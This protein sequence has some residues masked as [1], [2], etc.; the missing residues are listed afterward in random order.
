MTR[1]AWLVLLLPVA[2]IVG[3]SF[4]R[5]KTT[6]VRMG[7]SVRSGDA[8]VTMMSRLEPYAPTLHRNP[9]NDRYT[10]GLLIHSAR[11][12]SVRKF[13]TIV[14]GQR[15]VDTPLMDI[16]AV[17]GNVVWFRAAEV[18]AYD[19]ARGKLLADEPGWSSAPHAPAKQFSE[20]E[21]GRGE[22]A[23][24]AMLIAGGEPTP[25]QWLAALNETEI[26]RNWGYGPG[27]SITMSMPIERTKEPRRLY[28]TDTYRVNGDLRIRQ[29]EPLDSDSMMNAGFVR[30]TRYGDILRMAGG[31]FLL[32]WESTPSLDR[33]IMAARVDGAGKVVW[34][35][36]TGLGELFE[37]LPDPEFPAFVGERP[38]VPE[39]VPGPIL[40][41][42]DAATGQLTAHSLWLR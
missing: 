31:G 30:A 36:D 6:G 7:H 39:H 42:V 17:E 26:T 12:K 22:R 21:L 28:L 38:M 27:A 40:L 41:V 23:V 15:A 1:L 4:M 8:I 25:T 5:I 33:H 9:A 37:I 19:V 18:G 32:L 24:T 14:T 11:D 16:I 34:T 3:C 20:A 29:L 13:V 10:I 35:V 2:L